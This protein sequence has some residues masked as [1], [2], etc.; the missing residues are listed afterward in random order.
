MATTIGRATHIV[1]GMEPSLNR[2]T[3]QQVLA[4]VLE[5][6]KSKHI[7]YDNS[8]IGK[9]LSSAL[10]HLQE[11][12]TVTNN[13]IQ[14][15]PKV[16]G[17]VTSAIELMLQQVL[18]RN[19]QKH[20][21][22]PFKKV[23]FEHATDMFV[24]LHMTLTIQ[25]SASCNFDRFCE[26]IQAIGILFKID[27]DQKLNQANETTTGRQSMS[28]VE[29]E[30]T[31]LRRK[32]TKL[33]KTNASLRQQLS[34]LSQDDVTLSNHATQVRAWRKQLS[35]SDEQSLLQVKDIIHLQRQ[36]E[37]LKRRSN[38][39]RQL[40]QYYHENDDGYFES[41][42]PEDCDS[43]CYQGQVS[44]DQWIWGGAYVAWVPDVSAVF[45]HMSFRERNH[46][47]D[48]HDEFVANWPMPIELSDEKYLHRYRS[49]KNP[50]RAWDA[51]NTLRIY[52]A[53]RNSN[54]FRFAFRECHGKLIGI[55]QCIGNQRGIDGRTALDPSSAFVMTPQA[56]VY[57][58]SVEDGNDV[59][60]LCVGSDRSRDTISLSEMSNYLVFGT[61]LI[62]ALGRA[63]WLDRRIHSE[64]K[65]KLCSENSQSTTREDK[66]KFYY[67]CLCD[68]S[69]F[70]KYFKSQMLAKL[71]NSS[72]FEHGSLTFQYPVHSEV[73]MYR[74]RRNDEGDTSDPCPYIRQELVTLKANDLVS[75]LYTPTPKLE[76]YQSELGC[77]RI[78]NV[79]H[80]IILHEK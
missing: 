20:K 74:E 38:E 65:E 70:S 11:H 47:K 52:F 41:I 13:V 56:R 57:R 45:S 34:K 17:E 40:K 39:L 75:I 24:A 64:Y 68:R 71:P 72:Q 35:K 48:I 9:E 25:G 22:V 61:E 79:I 36:V 69:A 54:E 6:I 62:R 73:I 55:S 27:D 76:C 2:P 31:S 3:L 19:S 7:T 63:C 23:P 32:F 50:M 51:G 10:T 49:H 37:T 29:K 12:V 44:L 78:Q 46:R 42:D 28:K 21:K 18:E 16:M 5:C 59:I 1:Q 26:L 77:V 4:D 33:E 14:Y 43:G 66:I 80:S 58:I 60:H 8:R 67:Q 53:N 30:N 15:P